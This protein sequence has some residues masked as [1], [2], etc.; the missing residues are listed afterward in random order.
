MASQPCPDV[1]NWNVEQVLGRA[2]SGVV[3]YSGQFNAMPVAVKRVRSNQLAYQPND[4][5]RPILMQLDHPNVLK[6]FHIHQN[7]LNW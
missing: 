5:T 1:L 7:G 2:D 6:L 4:K 3:V